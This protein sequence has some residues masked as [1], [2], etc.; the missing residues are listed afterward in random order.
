MKFSDAIEKVQFPPISEVREWLAGHVFSA[1]RPMVDLC[2]AVPAYAPAP[3]LV[4]HLR[5][6][7][8]EADTSRY[9]IDEGLP[10]VRAAVA[11]WYGR[12]YPA[13]LKPGEIC[14]TIGASQAFW[15]AVTALCQ[16]GDEVILPAPA[17]FDHPMALQALGIVPSWIPFREASGGVPTVAEIEARITPRTRAVLLVTP[18]NP[19][20]AVL[21]PQLLDDIFALVRRH[22]LALILDETYNAF[23]PD[24]APPH[25]L[26]D[27]VG[28][29][30]HFVHLASF[31][32]TFSLTGYRAGALVAGEQ[33][34]RH[35]LKVQ[36]TQVVCQPRI[37]QHAIAFGCTHL[38]SWVS[39]R[40]TMMHHRHDL[41]CTGF[42]R[43]GNRFTRVASGGFFAWVRH[44]WPELTGRAAARR[45]LDEAGVLCLPGEAFGPGLEPYLRLA[46]GN[47]PDAGI[48][49]AID[50]FLTIFDI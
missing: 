30:D 48:P 29:Q 8:G 40:A 13:A 50:R 49:A 12:R 10:E 36:D 42:D 19:T 35:A 23:L 33:L 17:Y 14:L 34:I 43:P 18:N 27:T 15:L 7:V 24:G 9:S 20:G 39:E 46:F 47:L 28:W 38:D 5:E 45:M 32:K 2:Q 37:T 6:R 41:F 21:A 1:E 25:R 22:D 11:G 26:F 4:D 31:G 16:A 3:A 44:P